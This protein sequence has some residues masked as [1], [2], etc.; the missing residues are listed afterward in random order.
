M[1]LTRVFNTVSRNRENKHAW[2]QSV[3][4]ANKL[5]QQQQARCRYV[6][7]INTDPDCVVLT[8]NGM[9][10]IVGNKRRHVLAFNLRFIAYPEG[11]FH[12]PATQ[13]NVLTSYAIT[14]V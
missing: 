9:S 6:L 4:S 12:S 1:S 13:C 5:M 8:S 11:Q 10:L 14:A 7:K 3:T 2:L